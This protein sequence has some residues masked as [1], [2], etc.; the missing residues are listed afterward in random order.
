MTFKSD[1][2]NFVYK[3][4]YQKP[5]ENGW[6]DTVLRVVSHV[7]KAEETEE[8]Q[9]YWMRKFYQIIYERYFIPGGRI[10]ANAGTEI[11]NLMN[12][13]YMDIEDSRQGIYET[14]KNA[15]EI[16]AH[17]GGLGYNFS[18]LREKGAYIKGTGG[19]ASGPVSFMELFDTTG[20][21][22]EQA[23]RRGA[24]MAILNV[25]HPDIIEFINMK[26]TLSEKSK[27]FIATVKKLFEKREGEKLA[28]N[29]QKTIAE[30]LRDT[31]MTHFNISVGVLDDFMKAVK[32][33]KEWELVSPLDGKVKKKV[34]AKGLLKLMAARAWESGDPGVIFLD[35]VNE[36]NI[37]PYYGALRGS[38]PCIIGDTIL[39]NN[40]CNHEDCY[41]R[42]G[43]L[44]K[45]QA[46]PFY[47]KLENGILSRV[48][49]A[50]DKL[51]W[52]TGKK[53]VI[54]LKTKFGKE[55]TLTP[56]HLVKLSNGEWREAQ[57]LL[58]ETVIV[59]DNNTISEDVIIEIVEHEEP[60]DVFDFKVKEGEPESIAN[61]FVIHN[62]GE[63]FLFDK[64]AC[65]LG[66]I[67]LPKFYEEETNSINF[68]LLEEVIRISI[69]FLD[70]VITVSKTP[71]E[72]INKVVRS[73][74][75]M[76]LGVMGWADLLALLEI[77][78]NSEEAYKLA[79]YL[80]WFITAIAID[81]SYNLGEEKGAFEL[82]DSEKV[83]F[84]F[85]EKVMN[86]DGVNYNV[87]RPLRNVSWT[88]I[89]PTGSI[90]LIGEV[91]SAIEPFFALA[92]KRNISLGENDAIK[93][94]IIM[95]DLLESKLRKYGL[96]EEQIEEVKE[97]VLENGTL[98]DAPHVPEKLQKVFITSKELTPEEHIKMQAAWQKY[99]SNSVSKTINMPH[100][101][102][103]EDV[104]KAFMLMWEYRLKGGT[105]YR[106]KS[107][108]T[109]VLM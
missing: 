81:E 20:E 99:I 101:A 43:D 107:K 36:D 72:D 28:D 100:E 106:D 64:E 71:L 16:F 45:F 13:F 33:D 41:Y 105:I 24:Q 108:I 12:C 22:I 8:L 63:I 57:Y 59:Y 78:Y 98:K 103:I 2:A 74:R 70:D 95:N 7:A 84:A 69:R 79:E 90:A 54:T 58:N 31:Q 92:Y 3:S 17:G 34:K 18:Q 93:T 60:V 6:E 66:A 96:T 109:Q 51:I 25:D 83:N 37:V 94:V 9:N 91:N 85:I 21:V 47:T 11:E 19:K 82:Y 26:S 56:D 62:C 48:Y 87:K 23:S 40:K 14:L 102:T 1:V 10:L 104:E 52:W 65:N 50:G 89:Q 80:S 61:G 49:D 27:Q 15:A 77:P 86:R 46:T 35:R 76:G 97:Y 44:D 30:V 53:K 29:V 73:L 39:K 55:I 88:A 32:E 5:G 75:R 42:I 67:N 4:K 68:P 38:N